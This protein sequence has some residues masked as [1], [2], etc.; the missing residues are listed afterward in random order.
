ML[1]LLCAYFRTL[2][3]DELL[4]EQ[5]RLLENG[6]MSLECVLFVNIIYLKQNEKQIL[7]KE[8]CL[9]LCDRML[10][11]LT[12]GI[13]NASESAGAAGSK[14]CYLRLLR[15]REVGKLKGRL[16]DLSEHWSP[17]LGFKVNHDLSIS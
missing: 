17:M 13:C 4:W 8:K 12:A 10:S 14:Q 2:N 16:P 11:P 15:S 1:S 7:R 9:L 5:P 6:A 3:S